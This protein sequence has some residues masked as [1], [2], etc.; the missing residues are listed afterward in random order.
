MVTNFIGY[1]AVINFVI[2][3]FIIFFS[4]LYLNQTDAMGSGD[5]LKMERDTGII[6][7]KKTLETGKTYYESKTGSTFQFPKRGSFVTP[8]VIGDT[9]YFGSDKGLGY[10]FNLDCLDWRYSIIAHW[11]SPNV[12]EER[13]GFSVSL[14]SPDKKIFVG[15]KEIDITAS[16]RLGT[17]STIESFQS[18][19][20]IEDP[21]VGNERILAAQQAIKWILE[22]GLD[23]YKIS[24]DDPVKFNVEN[25]GGKQFVKTEVNVLSDSGYTTKKCTIWA[26]NFRGYRLRRAENLRWM[27]V[28]ICQVISD[29]TDYSN[30]LAKAYRILKTFEFDRSANVYPDFLQ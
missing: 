19:T 29:S 28:W 26:L 23:G 30:A 17:P 16:D 6:G 12:T 4:L 20:Y 9:A 24:S 11:S 14:E 10:S 13:V 21:F 7:E 1:K 15:T 8:R 22:K 3:I 5:E 25:I 18:K 27:G 2:V